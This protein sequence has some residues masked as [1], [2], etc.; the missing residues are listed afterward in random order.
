MQVATIR[1][2]T[3]GKNRRSGGSGGG[4][5]GGSG[6]GSDAKTPIDQYR[7]RLG[8]CVCVCVNDL[9]CGVKHRLKIPWDHDAC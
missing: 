4:G 6:G 5:G 9:I 2:S 7:K 1:F 8:T 3:M